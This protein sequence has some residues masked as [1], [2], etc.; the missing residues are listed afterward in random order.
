MTSGHGRHTQRPLPGNVPNGSLPK[1]N[2]LSTGLL[3]TLLRRRR[4]VATLLGRGSSV[5]LSVAG[6]SV[7]A[8]TV[9]RL[10]SCELEK[11]LGWIKAA[12][13][14]LQSLLRGRRTS[15]PE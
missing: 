6:L 11:K 13:N 7:S 10:A 9:V 3:V 4:V 15:A 12:Q 1:L 2:S 8:G 5:R 14:K